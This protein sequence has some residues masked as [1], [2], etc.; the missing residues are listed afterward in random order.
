VPL[1]SLPLDEFQAVHATFGQDVYQVFD[2]HRA[3]ERRTATGGTA[4]AAVER[5]IARA[6]AILDGREIG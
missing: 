6:R 2:P 5:Q 4:T 3:V 1:R